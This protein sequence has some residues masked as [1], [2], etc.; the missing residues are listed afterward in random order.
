MSFTPVPSRQNLRARHQLRAVVGRLL[1]FTLAFAAFLAVS[2]AA[3]AQLGGSAP[4][5]VHDAAALKP[6]PGARVAII[7]FDDM[8]CPACAEANPILMK[9]VATYHIPWIRHDFLI[10]EHTWSPAAA[11]FARWFDLHSKKLGSEYR[12]DVFANQS[13]I[14]NPGILRQ[15][16]QKFAQAH[17]IA[18]PFLVDP[19][20]KIFSQVQADV[21]LGRSVGINHTPTIFIAMARPG[22]DSFIEVQNPETDLFEDIDKAMAET[23]P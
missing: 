7:E 13:S 9:A 18:M 19:Q 16:T 8:E 2:P 10:P 11:V 1:S 22:G 17:G 21:D 3:R 5:Q 12:N 14:Y 23:R 6:P 15:F 20:G 4:T